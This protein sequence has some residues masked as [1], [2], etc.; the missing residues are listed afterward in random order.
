MLNTWINAAEGF[1]LVYAINDADSFSSLKTKYE[2]IQRNK[3][4]QNL[5]IN[6]LVVGNKCDLTQERKVSASEARNLCNSWDAKF[7][8]ASALVISN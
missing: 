1:L 7:I 8:E 2:A 5:P 6:I 4:S 3:K